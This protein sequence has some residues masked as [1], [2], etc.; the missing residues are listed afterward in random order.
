MKKAFIIITIL[1]LA[2]AGT[3]YYFY[4]KHEKQVAYERFLRDSLRQAREL[5]NA[6]IAA[7]EKAHRDS[8]AAYEKTHSPDVIKAMAEQLIAEEVMSGRNHIGGK[9]WSERINIL[10]EQCDNVVAY[11]TTGIDSIYK[12]FNFKGLMGEDIHVR[13]DSVMRV[14]YISPDSA[15]VDVHFNIGEEYPKGQTVTFKLVF[16]QEKWLID[17]F[18]F[19]YDD[20][21]FVRETDE[22]RWFIGKFGN[23]KE[24]EEDVPVE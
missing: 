20:G 12:S 16:E 9:N 1:I 22:M 6:R 4:D 3:G 8:I 7:I 5:E 24:D 18:T 11:D 2:A 19:M 14:Y 21:E 13:S 15:Y 23:I 10:R 17:D